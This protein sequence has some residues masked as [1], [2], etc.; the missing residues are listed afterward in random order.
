VCEIKFS[1]SEIGSSIIEEVEEKI[2]RL[3]KPNGFSCRAVL[4]HV[5]GAKDSV[6]NSGYFSKILDFGQLLQ[7]K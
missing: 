6:I 7:G 4:I 3:E 5:N 2:A 1:K